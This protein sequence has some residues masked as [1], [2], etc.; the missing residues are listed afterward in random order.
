MRL[1]QI[2][3]VAADLRPAETALLDALGLEVAF[4][5]PAI[6]QFGLRHGLYPVGDRLLEIVSPRTGDTTAG[7]Y[8]ERRGGDA[9]YMVILQTEDLAAAR[10]RVEG[11]GIR[12]VT[13]AEGPGVTGLHLHPKDVG[14]ALLSVDRAQPPDSWG[15]AGDDWRYHARGEVVTDL[16]GAEV[17][18]ADPDFV[19]ERWSVVAG[20][21]AHGRS[22][23][24]DDATISF[25]PADAR[26]DALSGMSLVAADRT[27]AG[28]SL[29]VCGTRIDLV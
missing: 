26:G 22:I 16:V 28:E 1:R 8:L 23:A 29:V 27:R 3:L 12:I 25:V 19:A 6:G 24:L 13:V 9:G 15:W 11:A 18:A 5:D 20:R 17:A 2:C 7:R 4:R 14:G 10:S 21:P